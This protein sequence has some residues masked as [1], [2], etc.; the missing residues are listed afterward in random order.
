MEQ[1]YYPYITNNARYACGVA[2]TNKSMSE[3]GR[4]RLVF[5]STDSNVDSILVDLNVPQRK[6]VKDL[7]SN[8]G[9]AFNASRTDW[10]CTIT[11][12]TG[13]IHPSAFLIDNKGGS[14]TFLECF[15]QNP[16]ISGLISK[17]IPDSFQKWGALPE[18][19]TYL[20]TQQHCKYLEAPGIEIFDFIFYEINLLYGVKTELCEASSR[21]TNSCMHPGV[22][23]AHGNGL[24]IRYWGYH[25]RQMNYD[26]LVH[27]LKRLHQIYPKA[28][29]IVGTVLEDEVKN[30][31]RPNHVIWITFNDDWNHAWNPDEY[32]THIHVGL[33]EREIAWEAVLE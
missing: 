22:S 15:R 21:D 11:A 33:S 2:L 27:F 23:H 12:F 19:I 16:T 31:F 8:W 10:M 9:V 24:D 1:F 4:V 14:T 13:E 20:G 28:H 26:V 30:R 18:Y 25:E 6:T 5:E 7:V 29:P 32:R 3:E 17:F